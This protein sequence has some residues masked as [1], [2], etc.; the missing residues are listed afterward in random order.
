MGSVGW[1]EAAKKDRGYR[2][3]ILGAEA[4]SPSLKLVGRF[5]CLRR[6]LI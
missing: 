3:A 5:E 6:W 4:A 2:M 1:A